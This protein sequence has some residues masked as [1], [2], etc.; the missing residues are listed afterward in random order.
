MGAINTFLTRLMSNTYRSLAES[1]AFFILLTPLIRMFI[2]RGSCVNELEYLIQFLDLNP[3]DTLSQTEGWRVIFSSFYERTLYTS[4]HARI[5]ITFSLKK[6]R[7]VL[8][9]IDP[10]LFFFII[11]IYFIESQNAAGKSSQK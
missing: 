10:N 5:N 1:F 8:Q 6:V 2:T 4:R 11:I 7:L 3:W 9:T